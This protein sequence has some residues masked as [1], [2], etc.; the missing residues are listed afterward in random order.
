MMSGDAVGSVRPPPLTQRSH[1]RLVTEYLPGGDERTFTVT[2]SAVAPG[3]CRC[4]TSLLPK[5]VRCGDEALVED[6]LH[7]GTFQICAGDAA[8]RRRVHPVS[9][10]ATRQPF[11]GPGTGAYF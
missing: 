6:D 5:G 11:A 10:S 4:P 9:R 8:E 7:D 1:R 3:H 2:P